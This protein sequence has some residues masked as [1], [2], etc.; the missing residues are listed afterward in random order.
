MYASYHPLRSMK[1]CTIRKPP[2]S[3]AVSGN[4]RRNASHA[5]FIRPSAASTCTFSL[6]R[7]KKLPHPLVLQLV[8]SMHQTIVSI[9]EPL[10]Q[11]HRAAAVLVGMQGQ[12]TTATSEKVIRGFHSPCMQRGTEGEGS[13][14][15]KHV[16]PG[17]PISVRVLSVHSTMILKL[18][19]LLPVLVLVPVSSYTSSNPHLPFSQ[20]S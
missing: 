7:P 16:V 20:M 13:F 11:I 3:Q 2:R 5:T 14:L 19:L 9:C 4:A 8:L 12:G 18:I 17:H 15:V 10:N 6:A 1:Y